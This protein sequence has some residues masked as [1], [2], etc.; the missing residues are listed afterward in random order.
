MKKSNVLFFVFLVG[1]VLA[2][3]SQKDE[4]QVTS[5]SSILKSASIASKYIVVLKAD[6]NLAQA[7]LKTRNSMVKG[8]ALGLLRKYEITDDPEE[9]YETALQ[10]FTVKMA[11]GQLKKMEIDS[12]VDYIEADKIM[13]LSPIEINGK[14]GGGGGTPA[15]TVPWGITRVGGGENYT[16]SGRAWVIDTGIDLDHPDLNVNA[17]LAATFVSRTS[18]ADDDNGHGTHCAG[19]IGAL[20]N[21]FGAIGVAAGAEVIPVKVLNRQGSGAYSTIISGVNYVATKGQSGDVANMSLGG[22]K[23]LALNEAVINTSIKGIKFSLAAGNEAT[24]ASTKSPA[25][26]E[27][28]DIYTISA[29]DANDNWASWSNYG[30]PVDYCAPGVSIYSTYK[31]GGY[32]TM[33]GTSMAAPHVAGLLLLGNIVTVGYVKNDPDGNPDPIAHR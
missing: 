6:E 20:G 2:G 22:P 4:L 5:D 26:A 1:L 14:P 12:D 24:D 3:C 21:S 27:A 23:D 10:G 9:I 17:D 30:A 8:K 29:M 15:Q 18:S 11:P 32:A 28:P 19:I 7:D 25:S 33:S 16:G 13:S 31:G